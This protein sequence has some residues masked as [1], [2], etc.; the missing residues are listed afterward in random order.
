LLTS[1]IMRRGGGEEGVKKK[2]KGKMNKVY[3][4]FFL[5]REKRRPFSP[6]LI[7]KEAEEEGVGGSQE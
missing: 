7:A 2:G 6:Y 5:N 1:S 3:S 4:P